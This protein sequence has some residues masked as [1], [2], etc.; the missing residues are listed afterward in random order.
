ME[1]DTLGALAS[2]RLM[3]ELG[4]D[5]FAQGGVEFLVFELIEDLLEEAEDQQFARDDRGMPRDSR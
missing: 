4:L 3:L 5:Q 2:L 1:V